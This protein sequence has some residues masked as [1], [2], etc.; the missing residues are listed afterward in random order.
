MKNIIFIVAI[1]SIL[2]SSCRNNSIKKS[3]THIHDDGTEHINHD[4]GAGMMPEQELFEVEIDSITIDKDSLISDHE[5]VHSHDGGQ[6]H[7]H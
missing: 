4:N 7:E 6:K 1:F 5:K 2:F 3:D